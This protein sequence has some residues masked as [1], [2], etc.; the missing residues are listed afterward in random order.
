MYGISIERRGKVGNIL[1]RE[2]LLKTRKKVLTS[3]EL[4]ARKNKNQRRRVRRL[5]EIEGK[6]CNVI[7]NELG[8]RQKDR[9]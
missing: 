3:D 4:E 9:N 6:E 8:V 2:S 7:S 5:M 1:Q